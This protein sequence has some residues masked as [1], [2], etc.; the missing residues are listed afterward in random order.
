MIFAARFSVPER[1]ICTIAS[2]YSYYQAPSGFCCLMQIRA[3][4]IL[5]SR[6]LMKG[7]DVLNS[8]LRSKKKTSSCKR[9]INVVK[10]SNQSINQSIKQSTNQT[11][12]EGDSK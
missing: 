9:P 4:V 6:G 10:K 8:G 3:F 2:F 1:V 12:S 7:K 11:I 5:T